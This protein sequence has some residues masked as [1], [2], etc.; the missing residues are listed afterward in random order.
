MPKDQQSLIDILSSINLIFKY[1]QDVDWHKLNVRDQDAIILRFI[2]IGE[3]TK[4]L[5]DSLRDRNPE[6]PWK[7][8]AALRDVVVHEYDDINLD[9]IQDVVELELPK[10]LPLLEDLIDSESP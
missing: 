1:S 4:R 6:I 3:A 9:I 8:M 7:Q 2:V 5:S 10:I